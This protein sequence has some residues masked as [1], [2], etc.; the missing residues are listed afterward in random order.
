MTNKYTNILLPTIDLLK[1]NP[2]RRCHHWNKRAPRTRIGSTRARPSG[3]S[4]NIGGYTTVFGYTK[5]SQIWGISQATQRVKEGSHLATRRHYKGYA[6]GYWT[7]WDS[8][9]KYI[10]GATTVTTDVR[11]AAR[12][13]NYQGATQSANKRQHWTTHRH[14]KGCA[15]RGYIEYSRSPLVCTAGHPVRRQ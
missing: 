9:Y 4:P 3:R 12:A 6:G 2:S 11:G 10:F 13:S 8:T 5:I 14:Y 1:S 15:G 7:G